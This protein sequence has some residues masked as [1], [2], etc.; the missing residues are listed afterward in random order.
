MNKIIKL[1]ILNTLRNKDKNKIYVIIITLFMMII[2]I[3]FSISFL[4]NQF[5]KEIISKSEFNNEVIIEILNSDL[6]LSIETLSEDLRSYEFIDKIDISKKNNYHIKSYIHITV[7]KNIGNIQYILENYFEEKI[8]SENY[9]IKNNN[10][11]DIDIKIIK[12][13][14]Y[15]VYFI[16]FI[17]LF[18]AFTSINIIIKKSLD[19]RVREIA[20]Y[21]SVG[22]KN[23]HLFRLILYELLIVVIISYIFSTILSILILSFLSKLFSDM[24]S[25]QLNIVNL[26]WI[27]NLLFIL[28]VLLISCISYILMIK[29]KKMSIIQLFNG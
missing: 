23:N 21:K 18:L 10:L 8:G 9:T 12:N 15:I 16:F 24:I 11:L 1:S 4:L 7:N 2:S 19:N 20:I 29:I 14:S 6:L 5:T 28:W 25:I 22:Y 13:I 17:I 26:I 27:Y 3:A